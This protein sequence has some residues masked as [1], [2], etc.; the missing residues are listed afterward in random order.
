[1]Y[2]FTHNDLAYLDEAVETHYNET[3]GQESLPSAPDTMR[4]FRLLVEHT[5]GIFEAMT[6]AFAQERV[7]IGRAMDNEVTLSNVLQRVSRKHAEIRREAGRFWLVDVGSKNATVLN[8]QRLE[9]QR[10]Y[11][12]RHGDRFLVGDYQID[13]VLLT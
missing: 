12:L 5:S 10:C 7:A 6:F 13:F 1:M 8:G 3:A 9:A 11:A 2:P 4:P